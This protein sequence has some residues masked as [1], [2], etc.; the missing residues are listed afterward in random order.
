MESASEARNLGRSYIR[1]DR[2]EEVLLSATVLPRLKW[3]KNKD[4]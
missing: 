2:M 3:Q 1:Q 4:N